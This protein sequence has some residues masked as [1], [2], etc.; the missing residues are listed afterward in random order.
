MSGSK[1]RALIAEWRKAITG[2]YPTSDTLFAACANQLEAA[3]DADIETLVELRDKRRE[4]AE[5]PVHGGD[6][7]SFHHYRDEAEGLD[8]AADFFSAGEDDGKPKTEEK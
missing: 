7:D 8:L 5:M 6:E 4:W 2:R 3:L 1:T